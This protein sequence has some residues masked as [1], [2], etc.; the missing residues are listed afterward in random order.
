MQQ[1]ARES[2]TLNIEMQTRAALAADVF[3]IRMLRTPLRSFVS[4]GPAPVNDALRQAEAAMEMGRYY[5]A[6][7]H[8]ERAR[9][10]DPMNPL[11]LI[12]KGHA[13][14]ASGDYVSAA[15]HLVRGLERF[16]ELTRFQVDLTAMMGGGE[17]VDIR[18]ADLMKLLAN[19]EEPELRFLL[20]YLEIHSGNRELGLQN[21]DRAAQ[22]A[23][24]GS[25]IRHYPDMIRG[26][27]L[28]P[29][30]KLPD[31]EAPSR[32]TPGESPVP[33]GDGAASTEEP[34]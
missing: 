6:A 25:L 12:G 2:P 33:S 21:L 17:I 10:L 27:G 8:Y 15:F 19:R 23:N 20:G 24:P 18:R 13:L 1:V 22:E 30:P 4:A 26:K 3:L 16:P 32:L 7:R 29:P 14:L 11:P 34:E 9:V 31:L 28:L 5:D